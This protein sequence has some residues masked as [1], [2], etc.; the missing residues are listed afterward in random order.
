MRSLVL[1]SFFCFAVPPS[2]A[3]SDEVVIEKRDIVSECTEARAIELKPGVCQ[4]VEVKVKTS[5]FR[6]WQKNLIGCT[7]RVRCYGRDGKRLASV[8]G[9]SVTDTSD[10]WATVSI[11]IDV[12]DATVRSEIEML[13]R[14]PISGVFRFRDI[15]VTEIPTEPAVVPSRA[16]TAVVD[17]SNRLIVDGRLFFPLGMFFE[18]WEPLDETNV[19][20]FADS[21]FNCVLP[22]GFPT[23][24][25]MD[26]FAAHGLKVV[27]SATAYYGTNWALGQVKGEADEEPWLIGK[28]MAFKNHP[29]LMC[30]YVDDEFPRGMHSRI[31]KRYDMLK[32]L[33]PVHPC[34]G[35]T[36][37]LQDC[38]RHMAFLDIHG[39]ETNLKRPH[40]PDRIGDVPDAIMATGG[41]RAVW[42]CIALYDWGGFDIAKL[43]EG[44]RPPTREESSC[45]IWSAI[46]GGANGIFLHG[47]TS[48]KFE[49]NGNSFATRWPVVKSLAEEVKRWEPVLLSD[50]GPAL[51]NVPKPLLAR[52]WREHDGRVAVLIVNPSRDRVIGKVSFAD[53]LSVDVDLGPLAHCFKPVGAAPAKPF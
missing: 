37:K 31:K 12:P 15:T 29:A 16:P 49:V 23:Q 11:V 42:S 5:G 32:A 24:E 44:S 10:G 35:F 36:D 26:R 18:A 50:P 21:P 53:G 46:A 9:W 2:F 14:Q 33:D 45:E 13:V 38:A 39:V 4:I 22:Y 25:E 19:S 20:V 48:I 47:Y 6:C 51:S 30:W 40:M 8:Y 34:V 52:A 41:K 7:A 17:A 43:K 1:F 27:Y 28:V 3:D